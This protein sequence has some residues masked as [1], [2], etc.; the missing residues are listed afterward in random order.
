MSSDHSEHKD[1]PMIPDVY[2]LQPDL[3]TN[4]IVRALRS[5]HL[6]N[7][8]ICAIQEALDGQKENASDMIRKALQ[9][10]WYVQHSNKF[11][12]NIEL[13]NVI[14]AKDTMTSVFQNEVQFRRIDNVIL[15]GINEMLPSGQVNRFLMGTMK[16]L[17]ASGKLDDIIEV[18]TRQMLHL[19]Q[20]DKTAMI[21]ISMVVPSRQ[22]DAIILDIL[23]EILNAGDL[24]DLLV[25]AV[26]EMLQCGK[27]DDIIMNIM[28]HLQ[29]EVRLEYC[30]ATPL[31]KSFKSPAPARIAW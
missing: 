20:D 15:M 16:N 10:V 23:V 13:S 6:N 28:T 24:D 11:M 26:S 1:E 5:A 25:S 7:L 17:L 22:L 31:T 2:T 3:M 27:L 18:G 29:K 21:Q 12:E 19:E 30:V 9:L 14:I 8:I 4:A